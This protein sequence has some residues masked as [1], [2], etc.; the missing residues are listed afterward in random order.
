MNK[1]KVCFV[2][3]DYSVGGVSRVVHDIIKN[4]DF[5]IFEIHVILLKQDM[6]FAKQAKIPKEVTIHIMDYYFDPDYSLKRYLIL[7]LFKNLTKK[8]AKKVLTKIQEINPDVLHFHCLPRELMIGIIA[9]R[10]NRNLQLIYTDHLLRITENDSTP[11]KRSIL[12]LIYK[13]LYRH[14]HV[15]SVSKSVKKYQEKY[16]WLNSNKSNL[17][18][19]NRVDLENY[20]QIIYE[21]QKIVNIVY[22][23]RLSNVKGHY[24]LLKAF[25]QIADENLVLNLVG[26]GEMAEELKN[27]CNEQ[28]ISNVIFHGN[29]TNV[30][31]FLNKMD[32]AVFPSNKEGLPISLLEKMASGLPIIVSDIPELTDF[33]ENQVN[34]LV[35]T[36]NNPTELKD[37]IRE[38]SDNLPLRKAL[39]MQARKTLELRFGEKNIGEITM[40]HYEE[41]LKH[42]SF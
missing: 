29:I 8:R 40:E 13:Y 18:I 36:R 41:V 28:L 10:K 27:F 34:G 17:L 25:K 21:D 9:K 16:R 6:E 23:A 42:C 7:A 5:Q 26:D 20:D 11:L 30:P 39:G 1:T 3:N 12:I 31:L 32:L 14:F 38:L 2:L 15:I 24:C 4:F 22:V 37:H 33:I 35:F 19:E